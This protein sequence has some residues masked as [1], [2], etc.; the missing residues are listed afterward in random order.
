VPISNGV[1]NTNLSATYLAGVPAGNG[2]GNIPINNGVVNTGLVAAS[3]SNATTVAGLTVGNASGNVP[4]SNGVINT[5]LNAASLNGIA[6]TGFARALGVGTVV[7][8][9][10]LGLTT[11]Y[12]VIPGCTISSWPGG[13]GTYLVIAHA[14]GTLAATDGASTVSAFFNGA[15]V[16]PVPALGLAETGHHSVGIC[17]AVT[18]TNTATD[19]LTLRATKASG[20]GGSTVDIADLTAIRIA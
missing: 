5:N 18:V 14:M 15:A 8:S 11:S 10:Q 4:V 2:A 3:A 19:I 9:A 13:A 20:S 1:Q 17:T 6:S 12:Q 7:N 16:G